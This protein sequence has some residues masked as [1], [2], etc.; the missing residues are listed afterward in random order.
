MENDNRKVKMVKMVK[1]LHFIRQAGVLT[2]KTQC[3]MVTDLTG[4]EN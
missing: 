3:S 4:H 1:M 2:S